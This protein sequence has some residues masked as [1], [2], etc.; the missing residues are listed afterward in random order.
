MCLLKQQ[1]KK[2]V[3]KMAIQIVNFLVSL[4]KHMN[5]P[6]IINENYHIQ[7]ST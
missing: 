7:Y 1:H 6:N 5:E 2:Y 3:D 4:R